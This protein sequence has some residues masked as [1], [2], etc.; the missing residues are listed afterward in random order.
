MNIQFHLTNSCN[1]RCKHCYQGEYDKQII[2]LDDFTYILDKTKKFFESI[3]DSFYSVSLT[4]GEPLIIPDIDKYILTADSFC[5]SIVLLSNG[6]LLTPDK[7]HLFKKAKHFRKIQVSLEGPEP[8]NDMIR[9]KGTYQKILNA[10][11]LIKNAGLF[12]SVSCTIAPY[13]YDK[14]TELY[15]DLVL[16][17]APNVLWFDRCIPFKETEVLTKEQFKYFIN[18]LHNLRLRWEKEKLPVVPR[19]SRALQWLA[20]DKIIDP[21]FCGAGLAHFTVMY[22]GDVMICRRLNFPVGNL[23]KEDWGDIIERISPFLLKMHSLPNECAGCKHAEICN[24]GLKCL[25]YTLFKDFNKKD[26]N[27]YLI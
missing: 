18:L 17:V 7:L 21:Y 26:V 8:I 10:I 12:T 1:L 20:D 19:A 2:S 5:E 4:G 3:N 15:D 6:I 27:C 9:G 22:N 16:K 23:F 24:G 14:I 25:T 13:N 11:S